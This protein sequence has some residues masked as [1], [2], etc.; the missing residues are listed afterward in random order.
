[1]IPLSTLFRLAAVALIA[2]LAIA[3]VVQTEPS[4]TH[5]GP[6]TDVGGGPVNG[7]TSS[8]TGSGDGAPSAKPILVQ[9]DTNQTMDVSPGQGVGVFTEYTAGGHWRVTWTCD[10]LVQ[11]NSTCPFIITVNV[12]SGAI[13]N[14]QAEKLEQKEDSLVTSDT[15][16]QATTL[17]TSD[18]DGVLF[19]TDP[20]AVITLSAQLNG[21]YTPDFLFFVQNGSV[22]G[23]FKGQLTDPLMLQGTTP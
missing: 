16:L 19:D 11:A 8:G 13:T 1:M 4:H 22:N 23:N 17:T 6:A 12:A 5:R 15:Q 14:A 2:P 21:Q 18:V 9:V 10:S 20:G 7:G 3:C